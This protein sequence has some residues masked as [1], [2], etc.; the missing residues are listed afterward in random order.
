MNTQKLCIFDFD[1]TLVNTIK[2]VAICFNE[3]LKQCDFETHK[4]EE[5]K[6]FVGGNL[7]TVV[8]RLLPASK[9][10]EEN[11]NKVK[12]IYYDIYMNSTKPNTKPYE[13]I[14]QVLEKLQENGVKLAIN[15]NKKQF[16]TEELCRKF[17]PNINFIK[18][19]GYSEDYPSKPNP[20]GVLDILNISQ[21]FNKNTFYIGDGKTDL[22][23]AQNANVNAILVKWGQAKDEDYTH[24]AINYVVENCDELFNIIIEKEIE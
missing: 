6:Y 9:R 23:T 2:D 17:F 15:T 11:I 10:N 20:K 5:Y 19:I 22:D 4:I 14:V 1:G 3:A 24:P 7:E 21:C 16:L 8:S 18:I 12:K 13:G